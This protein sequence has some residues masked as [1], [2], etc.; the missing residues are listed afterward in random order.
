MQICFFM[1]ATRKFVKAMGL[2]HFF[3][4]TGSF[5]LHCTRLYCLNSKKR[6]EYVAGEKY[7]AS[8][9]R[10]E[11]GYRRSLLSAGSIL[12]PPPPTLRRR[13]LG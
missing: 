6:L 5:A 3:M 10:G 1:L 9:G 12:P 4:T 11:R 2:V 13:T 7:E 8:D